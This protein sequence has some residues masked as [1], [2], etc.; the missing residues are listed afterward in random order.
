M[1]SKYNEGVKLDLINFFKKENE[2]MDLTVDLKKSK[3]DLI[4]LVRLGK[5][6]TKS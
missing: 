5:F 4:K 6:E 3:E 2:I 1:N